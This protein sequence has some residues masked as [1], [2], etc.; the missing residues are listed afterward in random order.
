MIRRLIPIVALGCALAAVSSMPARAQTGSACPASLRSVAGGLGDATSDGYDDGAHGDDAV[1]APGELIVGLRSDANLADLRCV[2]GELG[3]AIIGGGV[4]SRGLAGIDDLVVLQLGP[5]ASVTRTRT[6]LLQPRF[7]DL[8]A[9]AEENSI[10]SPKA[11]PT[12]NDPLYPFQWGVW[13]VG[14]IPR[15]ANPVGA[16]PTSDAMPAGVKRFS[17]RMPMAWQLLAKKPVLAPVELAIIDD[18]LVQHVDLEQNVSKT[19]SAKFTDGADGNQVQKIAVAPGSQFSLIRSGTTGCPLN[20]GDSAAVVKSVIQRRYTAF[21][22]ISEVTTELLTITATGGTFF[23]QSNAP[24]ARPRQAI[25]STTQ[26]LA[27]DIP[28]AALETAL[29]SLY[30]IGVGQVRVF[31]EQN[32]N[33]RILRI[34]IAKPNVQ[35]LVD[36]TGLTGP[37]VAAAADDALQVTDTGAG[38][39]TV[40]FPA[41]PAQAMTITPASRTNTVTAGGGVKITNDRWPGQQTPGRSTHGQNIAGMIGA[42]ANNGIGITGVLGSHTNV[43]ISGLVSGRLTEIVEAIRYAT[44]DL[45]ARVVNMSLGWGGQVGPVLQNPKAP[46]PMPLDSINRAVGNVTPDSRTLFVV[47]ASNEATNVN[48]PGPRN[49]DPLMNNRV[50]IPT[51]LYPCRPKGNGITQRPMDDV[52]PAQD[53][54]GRLSRLQMPDGTYDRGNL[55]CVGAVQWDG[56][57]ASFSMWGRNIIDVGAPGSNIIGTNAT[58]GYDSGSGTSYAAPYVAAVA[59][60]VYEVY[61][62]SQPWLVKCAILSSSTSQPLPAQNGA[63]LPFRS[64]AAGNAPTQFDANQVFTVHGMVTASEALSAAGALTSK[65]ADAQAG[66]GSWPTCVQK[67]R[68]SF[69]QT[70]LGRP[71]SWRDTPIAP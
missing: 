32:G 18:S 44:E 66:T 68:K 8:I 29:G 3:A 15:N 31:E 55:L 38:A 45:N 42:T 11:L 20:A 47:A 22:A 4:G 28:A 7:A 23:M 57:L 35:A 46:D 30:G 70:V 59:A 37:G 27:F 53:R 69:F 13:N 64:Y 6:F 67:R 58:G 39:W 54:G 25:L 63:E 9:S 36:G 26:P 21:C 40:R 48:D 51:D 62:N 50:P 1:Y 56:K 60:M 19:S 5:H 17:M 43:R 65:V 16:V 41:P 33:P 52:G 2:A 14:T 49:A 34:V 71:G 10:A 12:V 61:P 24:R